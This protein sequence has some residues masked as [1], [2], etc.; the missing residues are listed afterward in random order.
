MRLKG[1]VA[2]ITGAG[3]S[4]GRAIAI[5]YSAEGAK[6]V[7]NYH[8]K[9]ELAD[10]VVQLIRQRGGEAFAYKADVSNELEVQQM[11][12]E[13]VEKFGTVHILVNNAAIDPRKVWHEISVAEWDEV[14]ANNV[15][16]QFI[17]SKAVYPH[18]KQQRYGKIVNVSSVTFLTGQKNYVHYVASKGAI[19]GFTRALAREVGDDQITVNCITPGAVL[20]ETEIEKVGSVA[21]QEKATEMLLKVQAIPR[22]MLTGDIEG[23]F[24]FLASEE[25]DLI[26]GQT[27]NADG[28]WMMH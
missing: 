13:T 23:L 16:S 12:R 25:S 7:V 2:I 10:Q 19:I 26:T 9:P 14:M 22:R 8:S 11:V 21:A 3:Q 15:R 17:C 27:I 20:T 1:K 24:V 4:I 5:R 18:M 28:G 6:V